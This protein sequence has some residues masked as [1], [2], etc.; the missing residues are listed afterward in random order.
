MA[1]PREQQEAIDNLL[2]A[3]AEIDGKAKSLTTKAERD[4]LENLERIVAQ[5]TVSKNGDIRANL[6]NIKL[7][8][9]LRPA[10]RDALLSPAYR[11]LAGEIVTTINAISALQDVYFASLSISYERTAF[12]NALRTQTIDTVLDTMLGAGLDANLLAPISTILRQ[13]ITGGGSLS[14]LKAQLR[15]FISGNESVK[16]RVERYVTQIT[17]D[18]I[19]QYSAAYTQAA[20]EDLGLVWYIYAGSN[21]RTTRPFCEDR[22]G[23]FW[24]KSEVEAWA[25]Q[26]WQGKAAGTNGVSIFTLR[27]G[28]NC[29]H[30]LIPVSAAIVPESAKERLDK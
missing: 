1:L 20:S 21:I 11:R 6:N 17:T 28:Y 15:E 13:N 26:S 5:F 4:I 24:H 10:L 2:A 9:K 27:G 29:G 8:A 12:L 18:S 19:N 16:G 22:A 14:A 23:K 3:I 30:Q 25:S 7:L